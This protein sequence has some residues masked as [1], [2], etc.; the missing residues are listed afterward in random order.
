MKRVALLT[1]AP[2]ALSCAQP[3]D[4][5]TGPYREEPFANAV[6]PD[7]ELAEGQHYFLHGTWGTEQ[8]GGWPPAEFMLQLMDTEPEVFGDQFAS[9]GWLAD[10]ERDLPFGLA[11]G[12]VDDAQVRETCA[13]CHVSRLPDGRLWMGGPNTG[14][15]YVGFR[16]A[17]NERWV[18]AGHDSLLSDL[19]IAKAA[20]IGPGRV[21]ASTSTYPNPVPADFP[22]YFNLGVRTALNHI[23]TGGDIRSEVAMSI[24]SAGAGQT[25]DG[26]EIPWPSDAKMDAFLDFL[27]RLRAPENPAPPET[28][29][30]DRGRE[31][32]LQTRCHACHNP[33]DPTTNGVVTHRRDEP[34]RLPGEDPDFPR[35]TIDTSYAHRILVDGDPD[36][37][38]GGGGIDAGRIPLILFILGNGYAVGP[39]DGYRVPDLNGLWMS[40]PYLHN[41]SVPTLEDLL[42]PPDVRPKTFDRRGFVIDTEAF[43]ND[44]GGHAFG[45]DL[46]DEDNAALVA[47]LRTL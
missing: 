14:L 35:G 46:S 15:D 2:L 36:A 38:E 5:F 10:P 20:A 18:A 24:Y 13:A 33:V 1:L 41:G 37:E 26:L 17:V 29:L 23:G 7:H 47:Y 22:T 45:T 30:V 16:V 42:S 44:S 11:R 39:S 12:S 19:D 21:D 4:R 40:A 25:H 28:A 6:A 31:V 34:E 43:G 8:L 3:D 27:G 9:F 32:F